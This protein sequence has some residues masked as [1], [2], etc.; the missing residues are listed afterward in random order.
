MY[1]PRMC[2]GCS[3]GQRQDTGRGGQVARL[4]L[5]E[6]QIR[7]AM[8][9]GADDYVAKPFRMEEVV[10]RLRAGA[11]ERGLD[12]LFVTPSTNLAYAA[13]LA[14]GRSERL[15]AVVIP[16][17][18]EAIVVVAIELESEVSKE[19]K[20]DEDVDVRMRLALA[21]QRSGDVAAA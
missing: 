2:A 14:I 16:A 20:D 19:L 17:E 21:C 8:D 6:R 1:S 12:L 13:N 3:P 18:G 9:A 10:A 5:V 15:T 11:R 7:E 4:V